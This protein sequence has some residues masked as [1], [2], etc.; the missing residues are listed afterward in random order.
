MFKLFLNLAKSPQQLYNKWITNDY[1]NA[2]LTYKTC[3]G[4]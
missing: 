4:Q 2:R 3:I 1:K